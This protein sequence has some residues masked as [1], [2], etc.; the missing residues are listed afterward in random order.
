MT[1]LSA[2][3]SDYNVTLTSGK[4]LFTILTENSNSRVNIQSITLYSESETDI[5][6]SEDCVGLESFIDTYM[7][8]D[9]VENL[10]YCKDDQH[11]YYS[12]AKTA[13]NNLNQHQRLLFTSNVAYTSEWTRLSTWASFNGDSLNGSNILAAGQNINP[14]STLTE[15][16]TPMIIVVIVSIVSAI[17]IGGYFYLSKRK[18]HM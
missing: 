7:H 8:M 10:G 17:S 6:T 11:H 18:E 15:V 12:T 16:S 4:T 3:Y 13:F 2:D 9:Y 1:P 5:S 14:I